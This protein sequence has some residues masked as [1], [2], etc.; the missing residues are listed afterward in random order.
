MDLRYL[1]QQGRDPKN[2]EYIVMHDIT[3][4]GTDS[5]RVKK[6]TI[7]INVKSKTG[8]DGV[9]HGYGYNFNDKEAGQL[10]H[11]NYPWMLAENTEENIKIIK[12][13]DSLWAERDHLESR[14]CSC[15]KTIRTLEVK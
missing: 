4:L 6:G 13:Y 10:H 2:I 5:I 1:I 3:E 7:V 12:L 8:E 14:I 11:T 15:A 9:G